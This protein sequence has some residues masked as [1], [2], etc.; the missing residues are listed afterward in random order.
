[1]YL[2]VCYTKEDLAE[3][4]AKKD[5]GSS[6]SFSPTFSKCKKQRVI[7]SLLLTYLTRHAQ[8]MDAHKFQWISLKRTC[9]LLQTKPSTSPTLG[10]HHL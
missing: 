2:F 6:N 5:R 7:V 1:M 3:A 9:N 4:S 8:S 10:K